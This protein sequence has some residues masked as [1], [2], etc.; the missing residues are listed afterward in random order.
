MAERR[1]R[2]NIYLGPKE[3]ITLEGGGPDATKAFE[4]R[5]TFIERAKTHVF[6]EKKDGFWCCAT[7]EGGIITS[8]VS[9]TGVEFEGVEIFGLIEQRVA[10]SGSGR[11]IG[12]LTADLVG[13]EK[14]G[15][16]RLHLFDVLDWN[17]HDL[18]ELPQT[19]RREALEMVYGTF[20]VPAQATV[21]LVEQRT[22]GIVPWFYEVLKNGGEGIVAKDKRTKYKCANADG[23][24]DSW[25]RA[26]KKRTVDYVVMGHGLAEKGTPNL[27]LGLYKTFSTGIKLVKTCTVT[28]PPEW[29]GDLDAYVGE[30]VEAAGWEIFPSGA[31]RHAQLG[32]R[33]GPRTDKLPE[34]CTYEAAML[35]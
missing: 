14:V 17:G 13:S 15:T 19:E 1:K 16:R 12:E 29:R 11:I 28:V 24:I 35:A 4:D 5:L 30:V 26:K 34:D 33:P 6:E 27:D 18:R 9:R 22:S 2:I 8:M 31:L 20:S 21:Q 3:T 25:I 32:H 10:A 7:I 23:K